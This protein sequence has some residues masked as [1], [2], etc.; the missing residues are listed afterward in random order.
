MK[1]REITGH[2]STLIGWKLLLKF[3]KEPRLLK[4]ACISLDTTKCS[5]T[6]L[7]R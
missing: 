5:V 6:S 2:E 4:A 1:K 7:I 3:N